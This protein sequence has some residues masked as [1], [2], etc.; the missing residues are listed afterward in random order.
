MWAPNKDC[1]RRKGNIRAKVAAIK[2]LGNNL[3]HREKSLRWSM[4]RNIHLKEISEKFKQGNLWCI[5]LFNCMK[6]F[7]EA[8]EKLESK[9]EDYEKAKLI[10]EEGI[11]EDKD[12]VIRNSKNRV[13]VEGTSIQE[14]RDR[15]RRQKQVEVELEEVLI[16]RKKKRACL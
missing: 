16:R 4:G 14:I 2:V 13:K 11:E 3:N 1:C 10:L 7:E 5:L 15:K 9:K 6:G 12:V 8:K